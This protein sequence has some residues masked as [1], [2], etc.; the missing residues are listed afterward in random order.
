MV[1]LSEFG[2]ERLAD[3]LTLERTR[4]GVDGEL[5][6]DL[7]DVESALLPLESLVALHEVFA[8]LCDESDV[9]AECL[10]GETILDK[11]SL[12]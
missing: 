1:Q 3:L 6:H 5:G 10:L 12:R 2:I 11:L 8:F 4:G 7:G 9:G